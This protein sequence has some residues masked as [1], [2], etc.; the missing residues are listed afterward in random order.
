MSRSPAVTLKIDSLSAGYGDLRILKGASIEVHD[1]EIVVIVGPN[2]SGK[3]TLLKA[4]FGLIDV[5]DGSV[6][7]NGDNITSFAPEANVARGIGFVPQT[8]NIFPGLSI[9]ENLEIGCYLL[10]RLFRAN[11]DRVYG[12]FPT[13][14]ERRGHAAGSL[15]GGQR[16][17][18]A[19]GRAVM[20]EPTMIMLDEPSA[21]LSP[22]MADH[23]FDRLGELR[24]QGVSILLVEQ[25]VKGAL[26]ICDRAYVFAGG[27]D[28]LCDSGD[29][30][31]ANAEIR[32][33]YLGGE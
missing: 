2:G 26:A 13:L 5:F 14:A 4:A 9:E 7:H 3:S 21:G 24:A 20:M 10:P 31:L 6:H 12:M 25:N 16:Q 18:L 8:E 15:S 29:R 1:A 22:K 32:R 33:L 23:I 30:L 27:R 11:A 28:R 17:M 19:I